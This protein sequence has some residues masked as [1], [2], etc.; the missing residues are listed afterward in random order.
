MKKMISL[1]LCVLML[2]S[3]LTAAFAVTPRDIPGNGTGPMS[4]PDPGAEPMVIPCPNGC[5]PNNLGQPIPTGVSRVCDGSQCYDEETSYRVCRACGTRN[6]STKKSNYAYHDYNRGITSSC[7]GYTQTL[8]YGCTHGC[9]ATKS[10]TQA[11][12]MAGH[13]SN[14]CRWLPF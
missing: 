7:D 10:K 11:C 6:Y 5:N 1:L 4:Q 8:I 14:T 13:P 3:L 2:A 9:S 12:P